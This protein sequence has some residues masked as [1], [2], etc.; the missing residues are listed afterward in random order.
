MF[1]R[2]TQRAVADRYP[3]ARAM[4]LKLD[5]YR[6]PRANDPAAADG[7]HSTIEFLLR[8]MTFKRGFSSLSQH[9]SEILEITSDDSNAPASRLVNILAKDVTLSQRVLTMANSAYYGSA[10]ITALPRAIV[11][12]GLD[13][14]RMCITTALLNSNFEAGSEILR[15]SLTCSFHAA[16]LGKAIA[17]A[18][19]I[20]NRADAFT[21]ALY[22]NLGRFL[23]IHYF[24]DEFNTIRELAAQNHSDELT[25]SRAVL[26]VPY[27]ELGAGVAQQ[28]K[29]SQGIIAA[30]RPL[31]RGT[32]AELEDDDNARLRICCAY[33]NAVSQVVCEHDDPDHRDI[34]LAEL[35]GKVAAVCTLSRIE[36]DAALGES[37]KLTGPYARL[38][39]LDRSKH[40]EIERLVTFQTLAGAA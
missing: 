7:G 27:H 37:A 4:K 6:L 39:G 29:F 32:I 40:P 33:A 5:E 8:R 9:V 35:A 15:A 30:M 17:P 3:N 1:L 20:R 14:V 16:I 21:A 28:W 10:E 19:G 31:P 34:A 38:N 26:G 18:F 2:A 36:F 12:L 11:L 25:E 22:H 23:T 13:Q 24:E